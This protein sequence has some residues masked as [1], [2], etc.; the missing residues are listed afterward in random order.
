MLKHD[1]EALTD[2]YSILFDNLKP[3]RYKYNDGSSNRYHTGFILEELGLAIEKAGLTS[4]DCAAYCVSDF[5]TGIGG[6]RYEE[7]IALN[8]Q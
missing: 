7:L 5:E 1:I 2:N 3:V 8:V 4:Q 6:I